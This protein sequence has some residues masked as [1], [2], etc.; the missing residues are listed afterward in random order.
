MSKPDF[1]KS[2]LLIDLM[3]F[4][5]FVLLCLIWGTTWLAMKISLESVPPLTSVGLRFFMAFLV[6]LGC[7]LVL[8][9]PILFPKNQMVPFLLITTFYFLAPFSVLILGQQYISSGLAG[10]LYSSMP[11]FILIFS[12]IILKERFFL[13]QILG[14]VIGFFSLVM[15]VKLQYGHLHYLGI[16][17]VVFVMMA[18]IMHALAYVILKKVLSEMSTWTV[19]TLPIALSGILLI[20]FGFIGEQPQLTEIST[21]SLFGLIYLALCASFLGSLIYAFLLTRINTVVFSFVFIIFP[22]VAVLVSVWYENMPILEGFVFYMVIL[23]IGF[24]L[25][26]FPIELYRHRSLIRR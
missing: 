7:A 23:L 12:A 15:I 25:A 22:I 1:K 10:L 20:F 2:H 6:F 19:H 8:K 26:K 3:Y 17:G 11:A 14:I 4:V 24:A 18:A 9:K 21:R 5:L 16:K 13:S